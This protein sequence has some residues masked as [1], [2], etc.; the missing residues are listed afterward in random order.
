MLKN[1]RFHTCSA[2]FLFLMIVLFSSLPACNRKKALQEKPIDFT[3]LASSASDTP[4]TQPKLPPPRP[5]Q[6]TEAIDRVFGGAVH[7]DRSE[8][9]GF[10]VGDFN[11]DRSEDLAVWARAN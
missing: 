1:N 10:I 6:V 4:A 5:E 3:Q 2:S 7:I 9:P 8:T 11:G